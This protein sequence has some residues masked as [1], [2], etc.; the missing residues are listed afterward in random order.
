MIRKILPKYIQGTLFGER[1]KYGKTPWANDKDWN[2]WLSI[3]PQVYFDT[4]RAGSLQAYINDVGYGILKY[5]D[6]NDKIV[7]EIG[8]GG[9]YHFSNFS[10]NPKEYNAIDVCEDFFPHL[11]EKTEELAIPL[12]CHL[13][14]GE[15]PVL[16]LQTGSQDMVLSFYSLE[17]LN[18]LEAWLAEIQRILKPG[19]IFIG[20]VPAEGGLAW[21]MGR[22][23]TSRKILKRKYNLDISKIICWEHPNLIDDVYSALSTDFSLQKFQKFPCPFLPLDCNLIVKF[24][25]VR[26]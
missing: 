15:T 7:A 12:N 1:E 6:L 26:K 8:P 2:K 24:I 3:Y 10:G 22:Y 23:F 4:Q 13:I 19:G 11:K 18:P 25:A 17:H 9:G 21:G 20:A 5:I 14:R 16:P